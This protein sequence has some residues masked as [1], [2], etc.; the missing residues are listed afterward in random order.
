L[1]DII[2]QLGVGAEGAPAVLPGAPFGAG[3]GPVGGLDQIV[4]QIAGAARGGATATG[5]GRAA[6]TTYLKKNG[7]PVTEANIQYYLKNVSKSQ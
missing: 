3:A 1:D 5:G 7:L 4:Q 2:A 6:A